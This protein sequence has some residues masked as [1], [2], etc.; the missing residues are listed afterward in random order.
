[1][2][3]MDLHQAALGT[4]LERCSW[5]LKRHAGDSSSQ[6]PP[7]PA[8]CSNGAVTSIRLRELVK[9][10]HERGKWGTKPSVEKPSPAAQGGQETA[11][12]L[13]RSGGCRDCGAAV[14]GVGPTR[15]GRLQRRPPPLCPLRCP[16]PPARMGRP[17][18]ALAPRARSAE[19]R[20]CGASSADRE[21]AAAPRCGPGCKPRLSRAGPHSPAARSPVCAPIT[22][23][24]CGPSVCLP[25]GSGAG[26]QGGAVARARAVINRR[27]PAGHGAWGARLQRS[28]LGSVVPAACGCHAEAGPPVRQAAAAASLLPPSL[29]VPWAGICVRTL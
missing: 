18:A 25:Q 14:L 11:P 8:A 21:G 10:S 12:S 29:Q 19:R 4:L 24:E 23:P 28:R 27:L 17:E 7:F 26:E 20:G 6:S 5:R 13:Q 1:M 15:C 2:S 16:E 9:R 3:L 22:E